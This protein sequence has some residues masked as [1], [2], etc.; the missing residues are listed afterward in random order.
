M[1]DRCLIN[2]TRAFLKSP[3]HT[4][5]FSFENASLLKVKCKAQTDFGLFESTPLQLS[6]AKVSLRDSL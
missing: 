4:N 5:K 3:I 1:F 2:I 6:I